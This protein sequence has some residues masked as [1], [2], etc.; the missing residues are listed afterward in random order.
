[1]IRVKRVYERFDEADGYRVLVDRLWP[2]GVKKEEARLE[3]WMRDIAPSDALRREFR[4][5]PEKW[6]EFKRRYFKELDDNQGPVEEIMQ[7]ARS[8][9]VTLVYSAANTDLNNAVAL[10]EYLATKLG[11]PE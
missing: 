4:H 11:E 7:L 5:E 6:A 3:R 10:K 9:T 2:R 8:G 1:M